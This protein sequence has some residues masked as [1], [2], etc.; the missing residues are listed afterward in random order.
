[1]AVSGIFAFGLSRFTRIS[2]L[3][4]LIANKLY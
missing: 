4:L 1:L 2:T 3:S